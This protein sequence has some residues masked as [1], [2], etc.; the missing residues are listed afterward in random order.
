MACVLCLRTVT[1]CC[2]CVELLCGAAVLFLGARVRHAL[3]ESPLRL[4]QDFSGE[5]R[6]CMLLI[7]LINGDLHATTTY[8]GRQLLV[9]LVVYE[10]MPH[11]HVVHMCLGRRLASY[12]ASTGVCVLLTLVWA[13]VK[14]TMGSCL[15]DS[16]P[17][18]CGCQAATFHATHAW[19]MFFFFFSWRMCCACVLSPD[20]FQM[21]SACSLLGDSHS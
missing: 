5:T 21:T 1:A 6:D 4:P 14:R 13:S 11:V 3:Q 16:C 2:C 20:Q 10:R 18:A 15:S 7:V 8:K 19:R 9:C 12:Y 17:P